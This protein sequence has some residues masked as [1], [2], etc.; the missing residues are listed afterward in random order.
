[1]SDGCVPDDVSKGDN[2][3]DNTPPLVG[4]SSPVNNAT[5]TTSP[6]TIIADGGDGVNQSTPNKG[7]NKVEFYDGTTLIGTDTSFSSGTPGWSV[8]W[9]N[10]AA[11]N[12]PHTLTIK[13]YDFSNNVFDS[14]IIPVNVTINVGSTG[15]TQAPTANPTFPFVAAEETL[16]NNIIT[17]RSLRQVVIKPSVTDNVGVTSQTYKVNGVTKL[18]DANGNFA[19]DNKN[20]DYAFAI[21]ATDAA[22]NTLNRTITV[23]IRHPDIVRDNAVNFDDFTRLLIQWGTSNPE[24][25]LSGN[26]IVDFDD[27]TKLLLAWTG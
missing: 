10:Q 12:G 1:M 20:G 17:V 19:F 23:K 8:S 27:F 4:I 22:G 11:G 25:D 13:A 3:Y 9:N 7:I 26:N 18:L 16:V 21:T 24:T 6:T 5:I 14:S 2:C 15:D